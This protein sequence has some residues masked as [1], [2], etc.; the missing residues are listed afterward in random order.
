MEL[1]IIKGPLCMANTDLRAVG[2]VEMSGLTLS[3]GFGDFT[4]R[5][6]GLVVQRES[7][8]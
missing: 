5:L 3:E 7:D 6:Q 1:F 2:A 8:L 4:M